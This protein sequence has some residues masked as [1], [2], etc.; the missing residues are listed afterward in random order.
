MSYYLWTESSN[1]VSSM[2]NKTLKTI[3]ETHA[4]PHTSYKMPQKEH[5]RFKNQN[6]T[7]QSQPL[8]KVLSILLQN[9]Q[10]LYS[11]LKA[12]DVSIVFP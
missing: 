12:L 11:M 8:V 9:S 6:E 3:F 7:V 10:S 1:T 4:L 2:K 5:T